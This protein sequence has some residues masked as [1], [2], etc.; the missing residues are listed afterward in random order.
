MLLATFN[1]LNKPMG[2]GNFHTYEID[3]P[4]PHDKNYVHEKIPYTQLQFGT[5]PS[6][7]GFWINGWKYNWGA[8]E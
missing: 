4:R 2:I 8:Q 6:I 5:D 1:E 7:D 3:T